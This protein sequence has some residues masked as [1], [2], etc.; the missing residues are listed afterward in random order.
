MLSNLAF[1]KI[2]FIQQQ[3]WQTMTLSSRKNTFRGKAAQR[4]T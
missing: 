4:K 3:Q 1:A 2:S